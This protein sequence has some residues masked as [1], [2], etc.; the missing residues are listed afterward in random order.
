MAEIDIKFGLKTVL[1]RIEDAALKRSQELQYVKPTLVAASKTNPAE[2]IIAAYQAGQRH[3]GENYVQELVEKG[4]HA[5]VL[6]KCKDIKW[7]LIGHLQSNKINKVLSMPN[8]YLLETV[9]S[10]KLATAL[11]KAW[12]KYGAPN[13]QLKVMIQVNTSLEDVK[14]GVPP[15]E[16]ATLAKYIMESCPNLKL[17]G[18]MTIGKYGYNPEDGPNPD[19]LCLRKC[20]QDV[21]QS[22]NIDWKQFQLSMGMSTDY[23]QAVELGSTMV[24]VG[25]AIF[26]AR[27]KQE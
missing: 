10:D 12:P 1:A 6:E 26:G 25:T 16:V 7:H 15:E 20:R 11:N 22:L 14:S 13:T 21:C 5:D 23:E 19:F 4:N 18:L 24:R 3:F 2:S 17:E 27:A 8:F 9:D